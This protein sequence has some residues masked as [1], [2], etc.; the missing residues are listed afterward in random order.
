MTLQVLQERLGYK[1][2]H[3]YALEKALRHTSWANEQV[4]KMES[5]ERLEFL[6]DS[7]LDLLCAEWL[8]TQ[9]PESR[10]GPL[11]QARAKLVCMPA[12]AQR[13]KE[14]GLGELLQLG[15]GS[16]YLREVD[17]VL[18]DAMEAIIGAAYLDRGLQAAR[19]VATN[20]GILRKEG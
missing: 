6:G 1:F 14:L 18:A 10:E 2:D 20:V 3:P 5:N 15:K 17:S 16:V 11:S 8:M 12:L 7:V 19:M 9:M 13:A 4:P